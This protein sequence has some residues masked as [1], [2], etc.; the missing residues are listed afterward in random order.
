MSSERFEDCDDDFKAAMG[1]IRTDLRVISKRTGEQKKSTIRKLERRAEDAERVLQEM[2]SEAQ[3]APASFRM[4]MH[5]KVV[6]HRSDLEKAKRE[7][8]QA[9][10]AASSRDDLLAGGRTYGTQDPAVIEA[11]QR[12]RLLKGSESLNRASESIARSKQV[13]AESETIG[14]E[15]LEEL[16]GQREQLLRA[17]ATVKETDDQVSKAKRILISM[18]KRVVTDKLIMIT[19][20][21]LEL[22]IIG[23]VVYWKF[24]S[25]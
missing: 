2:E 10:S 6:K 5:S 9:S 20:I 12:N 17:G 22:G 23:G 24:F 15:T 7:L 16:V 25:K 19:I 1:D 21:L 4:S 8:R 11:S 13:A 14:V 18:G 3:I